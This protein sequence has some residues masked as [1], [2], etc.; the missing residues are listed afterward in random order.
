MCQAT[1]LA[2]AARAW[3]T[4]SRPG[5]TAAAEPRAASCRAV[6]A[7]RLSPLDQAADEANSHWLPLP[8]SGVAMPAATVACCVSH[9]A[10]STVPPTSPPPPKPPRALPA[11]LRRSA[12]MRS[13]G[14]GADGRSPAASRFSTRSA[15][16]WSEVARWA[17]LAS[18]LRCALLAPGPSLVPPAARPGTATGP[19]RCPGKTRCPR[20]VVAAPP[21]C[22]PAVRDPS[23]AECSPHLPP[24]A[25]PRPRIGPWPHATPSSIQDAMLAVD[26][27]GRSPLEL[28]AADFSARP[29]AS[30]LSWPMASPALWPAGPL[31]FWSE[32]PA[33]M[34]PWPMIP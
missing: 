1:L 31:A 2:A 23:P 17:F 11:I 18:S 25:S 19:P 8:A 4:P 13:A 20:I 16:A 22:G 12:A 28:G 15:C 26:V 21:P 30:G 33:T 32:P 14:D 6:T 7:P 5:S 24:G 27:M 29:A 9:S 3:S 34:T 10:I